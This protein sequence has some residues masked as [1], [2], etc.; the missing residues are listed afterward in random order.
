MH[1]KV[2]PRQGRT[3]ADSVC[4]VGFIVKSQSEITLDLSL[5]ATLSD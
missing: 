4:D 2:T 5:K 3:G 1:G